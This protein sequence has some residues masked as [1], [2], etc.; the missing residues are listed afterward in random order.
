MT[1]VEDA[2]RLFTDRTGLPSSTIHLLGYVGSISHGTHTPSEDPASIDDVDLMGIVIPPPE[3]VLGGTAEWEHVVIQEGVI[4][5]VFYSLRKASG[6]LMKANPNIVGLLWLDPTFYP[7]RTGIGQQLIV[8]RDLFATTACYHSFIGYA[9]GQ[10]HR[11]EAFDTSR[12]DEYEWLTGRLIQFYPIREVLE[13]D[14]MKLAHIIRALDGTL[15]ADQVHRF[16]SLHKQYFSGYMGE[17]RKK[18]VREKG[19]DTKNAAHLIRLMRMCCEFLVTGRLVVNRAGLDAEELKAIKR[20]DWS[21]AEVKAE[22]ESLFARAK[23]LRASATLPERSDPEAVARLVS[24][25]HLSA[26]QL[27]SLGD[28]T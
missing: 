26:W 7:I 15:N 10:L 14:A 11:M 4:D 18:I 19:Y 28:P 3:R 12:M 27:A 17:K 5:A 1:V 22:A 25:L 16:R 21:I 24:A 23:D 6:L 8:R 9:Y 2:L 13:A 20:G